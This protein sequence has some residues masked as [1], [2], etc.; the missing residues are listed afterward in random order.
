MA[1]LQTLSERQMLENK[2]AR[3]RGNLLVVVAFTVIN[4]ILLITD[5]N[6][7]FLFSAFIPYLLVGSGMY[8]GGKFPDE[9]YEGDLETLESAVPAAFTVMLVIAI[10]IVALYLLCWIFSKKK[11]TGWL[12]VALVFFA[13]DTLGMLFLGGVELESVVDIVFH[14]WVI[15]SLVMGVMA[16]SKLKKL[17]PEEAMVAEGEEMTTD[18]VM[19]ESSDIDESLESII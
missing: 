6:T 14:G 16:G 12:I 3:A 15:V 1:M 7:Y 9:Y 2:Y 19:E 11:R 18:S 13:L 5:S 17:P 4:M 8:A 10:L